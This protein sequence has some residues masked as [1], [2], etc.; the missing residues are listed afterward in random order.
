MGFSLN[1]SLGEISQLITNANSFSLI[2]N[3][4]FEVMFPKLVGKE[5]SISSKFNFLIDSLCWA[6]IFVPLVAVSLLDLSSSTPKDTSNQVKF[7]NNK[8]D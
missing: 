8:M 2:S 7:I 5:T 3:G 6:S 1:G 4:D